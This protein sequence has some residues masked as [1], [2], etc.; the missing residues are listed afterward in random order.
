MAG[1]FCTDWL[2]Q[3]EM[4]AIAARAK[5]GKTTR[6]VLIET[7]TR[8]VHLQGYQNTTLDDVLGASGVG[9]GNF[10]HYF[11]SKEDLG[12]AILDRVIEAFMERGIE[13]CFADPDAPR[14]GQIRCF[15]ARVREALHARNCAGGCLFGNLAAELADVHEGFRARL[16]GLL[17]EAQARGEVTEQCRPEAVAPFLVASLEGAMLLTKLTKDIAVMDRCVEEMNH[18]LALYERT[19]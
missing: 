6:E 17:T 2:V 4:T 8:L 14:L 7:A 9:K 13:P 16:A 10:Y 19:R 5:E 3:R 18:Y 12:F 11:R 15:L 1:M